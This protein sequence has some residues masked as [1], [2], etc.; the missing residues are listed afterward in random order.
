MLSGVALFA[1]YYYDNCY[2]FAGLNCGYVH[3]ITDP[4]DLIIEY[5]VVTDP[6]GHNTSLV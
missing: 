3:W 1:V 5:G 2:A 4:V 6:V